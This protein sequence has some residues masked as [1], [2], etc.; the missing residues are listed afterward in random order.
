MRILV[1]GANGLIGA[2]VTARLLAE[3]HGVVGVGRDL[4]A[5]R[6]RQPRVDWRRVDLGALDAATAAGLLAGVQAVV[7]CAGALQDGPDDRL[8]RIH[9]SAVGILAS[10]CAELGVRRFV[11]ISAT[12][13]DRS[14]TAFSTTKRAG[15][16]ALAGFDLDW[17]VLRP[18]LVLGRAAYG[19]SALLRARRGCSPASTRSSTAPGRCRMGRTTAW[20]GST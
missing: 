12:G 6:R 16:A 15:E 2:A 11:L 18:G 13:I 4:A 5:A 8:S 1:L 10:A 3:G 7:D 19:G 20:R 14:D 9:V 17:V